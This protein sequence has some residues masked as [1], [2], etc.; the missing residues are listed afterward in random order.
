MRAVIV[1]DTEHPHR[2]LEEHPVGVHR[3]L[4]EVSCGSQP[5]HQED[6]DLAQPLT[7]KDDREWLGGILIFLGSPDVL[8]KVFTHVHFLFHHSCTIKSV[9]RATYQAET[10]QLQLGVEQVDVLR[11]AVADMFGRL[12]RRDW[13]R[14]APRFCKNVWAT[15][16]NITTTSLVKPV[17]DKLADRR[18]AIEVASLLDEGLGR[19]WVNPRWRASGRFLRR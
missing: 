15:D 11:P 5:A 14:S 19:R 2:F 1:G 3:E 12:D 8:K 4:I 6:Q 18:L 10:Y 9:C 7:V 13:E 17:L 16:C